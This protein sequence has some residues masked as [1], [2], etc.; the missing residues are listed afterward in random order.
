MIAASSGTQMRSVVVRKRK[1][2]RDP[3]FV[4]AD[5]KRARAQ[6]F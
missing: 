5:V 6:I 1:I 3:R 2:A 4:L